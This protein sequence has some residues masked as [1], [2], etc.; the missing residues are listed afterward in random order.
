[1]SRQ[2]GSALGVALLVAL[3]GGSSPYL[4]RQFQHGWWLE[5]S[6]ALVAALVIVSRLP[7]GGGPDLRGRR[8]RPV[9]LARRARTEGWPA[10]DLSGQLTED[11]LISQSRRYCAR[12]ASALSP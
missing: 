6:V 11:Q 4:L 8:R 10:R 1:M 3:V 9:R 2:L 5:F 7:A 12:R